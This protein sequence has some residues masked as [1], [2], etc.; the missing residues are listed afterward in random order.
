MILK[1]SRANTKKKKGRKSE[2]GGAPEPDGSARAA[3]SG[4]SVRQNSRKSENLNQNQT[5]SGFQLPRGLSL[6]LFGHEFCFFRPAEYC[7]V[8]FNVFQ[9]LDDDKCSLH[10]D[11]AEEEVASILASEK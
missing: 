7:S 4:R 6:P 2:G 5:N 11:E 3:T 9:L 8:C 1:L 10:E